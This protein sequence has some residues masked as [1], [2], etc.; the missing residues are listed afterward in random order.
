MITTRFASR[1]LASTALSAVAFTGLSGLAAADTPPFDPGPEIAFPPPTIPLPDPVPALDLPLADA[2]GLLPQGCEQPDPDPEPPALDLPLADACGLLPEGCEQP[3]P[4]PD[5]PVGADD[6]TDDP[7]NHITHGCG[8]DDD[9]VDDF[10]TLPEDPDTPV[11]P[12]GKVEPDPSD[13]DDG[14]DPS[15]AL[16]R[17]GFEVAGIV[18]LGAALVGAGAAARRLA[19]R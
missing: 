3:D 13:P 7:C 15:G 9:A 5:P 2:C 12:D 18:G 6:F 16:P 1:M 17:T 11:D 19:R 8:E 10:T 4:D 14:K